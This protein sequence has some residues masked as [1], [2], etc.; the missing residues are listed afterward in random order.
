MSSERVERRV[1]DGDLMD[2]RLF[3]ETDDGMV[4]DRGGMGLS[5][6]SGGR[7]E[8]SLAR[9]VSWHRFGYVLSIKGQK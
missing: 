2:L 6:A 8:R 9:I 5:L 1:L 7:G 3:R 4:G